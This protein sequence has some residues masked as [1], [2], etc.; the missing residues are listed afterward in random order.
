M[1]TLEGA[2]STA[3]VD[4]GKAAIFTSEARRIAGVNQILGERRLA[5]SPLARCLG[6]LLVALDWFGA[7]RTL[8]ASLG[9]DGRP[10]NAG[11][12]RELLRGIGFRM[13]R[14]TWGNWG[15]GVDALPI[16]SIVVSGDAAR[17]YLG[18]RDGA[19]WCHDGAR[20]AG[21]AVPAAADTL[22]L[23]TRDADFKPI[24]APQPGWLTRLLFRTRR[25]MT[26]VLTLSLVANLLTLGVSLFTMVVYNLVIPSG[27]V[28]TLEALGIG[29]LFAAVAAWGLRVA[30]AGV[31]A[32]L[33]A[34]AGTRIGGAVMRKT[35]GLPLDLSAR[36]GVENNLVR[37]RSMEGVRQFIGGSS[38]ASLIDYPFI[39]VVLLVIALLGGWIVFVPLAGLLLFAAFS[40]PLSAFVEARANR[41]GRLSR[42]QQEVFTTAIR[43]LRALRGVSGSVFWR[44]RLAE[45]VAQQAE[46]NRD[47][48]LA[49]ALVQSVG[50]AIGMLTV[51]GTMG[52][53]ILLVLD[54]TMTT[55][56]LI[57]AMMLIWRVTTPAQ[58][59]FAARVQWRQI[60]DSARQLDRLML[61]AGEQQDPQAVS[62]MTGVAP[63][64]ASDRAYYR[65]SADAEAALAGISFAVE[66]GQVLAV[67][68]PNGAGKTTLLECLAGIR[69]TQ[70]GMITVGGRDI[71]QFDPADY[72]AWAGYLPQ[73]VQALPLTVRETLRLRVPTAD[74]S[75]QLA[76]LERA[77]GPRWWSFLGAASPEDGLAARLDPW[78]EDRDAVRARFVVKLAS[79]TL[80]DPPLVILDDPLG[81]IDPQLEGQFQALLAALRGRSTI[82]I[83]THRPDLIQQADCIAVLN[84]GALVHFGPVGAPKTEETQGS[85]A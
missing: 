79:A 46:A 70:S 38:G 22:L 69:P 35:L 76:A 41:V 57:A 65:F 12:L 33:G 29:A 51:L 18:R 14:L 26:G 15:G 64:L 61:T 8:V 4:T 27:A 45:M 11:H 42:I 58:Q 10:M 7:P 66:P 6:P 56:G 78:R 23:V 2:V 30:R 81:D 53:G 20:V 21:G 17:V 39:A 40:W 60:V 25:E 5:A 47:F 55:G 24:D 54:G 3:A 34:W 59:A 77:A 83:A 16:G 63:A 48:A 43:R 1:S 32:R 84:N 37:I 13:R 67:V 28:G 62:P 85:A 31:L 80:G 19:D 49:N 44:R 82:V 71:R 50:S 75:A 73:G 74:D 36:L 72:R 9:D 68:G 52:V